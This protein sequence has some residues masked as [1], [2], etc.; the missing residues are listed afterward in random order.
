MTQQ[1]KTAL[2]I[3]NGTNFQSGDHSLSL[4]ACPAGRSEASTARNDDPISSLSIV[5]GA[6]PQAPL[7]VPSAFVVTLVAKEE[8]SLLGCCSQR[9]LDAH[10][11]CDALNDATT[12]RFA[13]RIP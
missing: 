13:H 6:V 11:P 7:R 3:R 10:L 9:F 12:D 1:I 4:T 5:I 8:F 2:G